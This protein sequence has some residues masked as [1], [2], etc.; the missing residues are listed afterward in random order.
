MRATH[1][2]SVLGWVAVVRHRL[3]AIAGVIVVA[4]CLTSAQQATAGLL[5]SDQDFKLMAWQGFAQAIDGP[6]PQGSTL[7]GYSWSMQWFKGKLY[8]GTL[9]FQNDGTLSGLQN[10]VGQIWAYTPAAPGGA[11]GTWSLALQSPQGLISPREF[12][13]RWMTVCNFNGVDYMFVATA[14][15]LQGNI[16]RTTDGVTF[17][18]LSRTGYPPNSVGFR[19]LACFTDGNNKQMLVASEVGIP[20]NAQTYDANNSNS[21]IVL[22]NDDPTGYGTWRNYSLL[23]MGDPNNGV[24]FTL[25]VAGGALYASAANNV[26][27]GQLWR[28]TGCTGRTPCIP[29]WTKVID[30]GAGRPLDANGVVQNSGISDMVEYNGWLYMGVDKAGKVKPA[31]EMLRLRMSDNRLEVIVGEPRL[32]F[33]NDPNAPPTNPAFPPNLRCGV[34]LE[35][36]D[37]VGGA[38]D[39]PP[40]SRRGAGFGVESDAAGG[41]PTG[42]QLYFWRLL[43]YAF[44]ASAAPLGDG[45]LYAG[46]LDGSLGG[47][48]IIVTADGSKWT[49]VTTDGLGDPTQIG[50][51]GIASSPIGLWVG[52]ASRTITG[53]GSGT[54]VWLGFPSPDKIAPV[55]TLTS[56]PSPAEGSTVTAHNVSFGWTG[57]D[58]PGTGSLPLTFASRLDP[59]EPSFSVFG[60][61][62][63]KTYASLLNGTYTFYVIARDAAGNTETPGAAAGASNRTT[64]TVNA[65]DLPPTVTIQVGPA[66]PDTTGIAQFVWQGSD[67]LTPPANL[68]Y[69]YWLAPLQTDAGTFAAGTSAN[70]SG[71]TNGAYTFHV[72]ARDGTGNVGAEATLD[73]TVAIPLGPPAPPTPVAANVIAA[74]TV[75]VTWTNVANETSYKIERCVSG[76]LCAFTSV[77][78]NVPAD[79]TSY[80]DAVGAGPRTWFLY[81]VAACN[82][83]GCSAWVTSP[84]VVVP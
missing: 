23:G 4:A 29:T 64:F 77:A 69:D 6:H 12:G 80:D 34:P 51:R 48:D 68:V 72:K 13:Y 62:T 11:S 8:V 36:L 82:A 73:F 18:P 75:R 35:D 66:S 22:V 31:A 71:L 54:D 84:P 61:A 49:T 16:L 65:P 39:C 27:G 76:P 21:P 40:A 2:Q 20:G 59:I 10:M 83:A 41:Y 37:G 26:S 28:T 46:T 70:Y 43:N 19:T 7:N 78:P 3:F 45:R 25:K 57:T 17:T 55:S 32:N 14:G 5:S 79:T 9:V 52:G 56:P 53:G 24:L 15:W 33:G 1:L 50:M 60:A 30:R 38:N 81:R 67:D 58:L 42:A 47:F 74:R 63:G 44:D